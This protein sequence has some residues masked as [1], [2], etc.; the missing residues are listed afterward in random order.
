MIYINKL[1][2]LKDVFIGDIGMKTGFILK[3]FF[4]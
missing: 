4:V 1:I 3:Y 2:Y